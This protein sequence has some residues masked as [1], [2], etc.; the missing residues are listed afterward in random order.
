MKINYNKHVW[1]GWLVKDFIKEFC[2]NP[3]KLK[4]LNMEKFILV[5]WEKFGLEETIANKC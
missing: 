4:K 1:E 2:P 5:K 3:I